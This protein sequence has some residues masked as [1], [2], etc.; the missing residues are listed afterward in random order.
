MKHYSFIEVGTSDFASLTSQKCYRDK[1]GISIE[2]VKK[3]LDRLPI[4][5]NHIKVCKALDITSG[6][7]D[8]YKYIDEY[9]D[10]PANSGDK[11][12]YERGMSCLATTDNLEKRITSSVRNDRFEITQ[13]ETITWSQL[14][15]EYDIGSVDY[16]KIDTEGYDAYLL[17]ELRKTILRPDRIKFEYCHH[18]EEILQE[19]LELWSDYKIE[20][21]TKNDYYL[22]KDI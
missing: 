16:L 5:E 18:S 20:R 17:I 3:L 4:S 7:K 22:C 11:H 14:I 10:I 12:A 19:V 21:K 1:L 8:F 15:E 2:P 6:K 9:L 13:V